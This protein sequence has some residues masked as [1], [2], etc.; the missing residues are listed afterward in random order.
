MTPPKEMKCVQA[1][2]SSLRVLLVLVDTRETTRGT[3]RGEVDGRMGGLGVNESKR[4]RFNGRAHVSSHCGRHA[5]GGPSGRL[6]A[7]IPL[8]I[9]PFLSP[10]MPLLL[11][12]NDAYDSND[13][14]LTPTIV[15][16]TTAPS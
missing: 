11:P 9:R 13:E 12:L 4:R 8:S 16:L 5:Q 7:E 14:Y 6:G 10:S 1:Q 3:T 15:D 2:S